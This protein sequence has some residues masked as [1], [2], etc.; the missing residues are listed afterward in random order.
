MKPE[1]CTYQPKNSSYQS[2]W[3]FAIERGNIPEKT[4]NEFH[5]KDARIAKRVLL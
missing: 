1:T 3:L 4:R 2:F 5:A